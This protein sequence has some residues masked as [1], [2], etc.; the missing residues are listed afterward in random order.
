M[1]MISFSSSES[2][3][4]S[5]LLSMQ[6]AIT[7][8]YRSVSSA[9]LIATN[10]GSISSFSA[11]SLDGSSLDLGKVSLASVKD[12]WCGTS[13]H[14]LLVN[15]AVPNQNDR[16]TNLDGIVYIPDFLADKII[17]EKT[18]ESVSSY[19]DIVNQKIGLKIADSNGISKRYRIANVF[20]VNGFEYLRDSNTYDYDDLNHGEILESFIGPFLIV[21]DL[22]FFSI[23]NP[24]LAYVFPSSPFS[25]KKLGSLLLNNYEKGVLSIV[26]YSSI[27]SSLT[28]ISDVGDFAQLYYKG[29]S[30]FDGTD[31][32]AFSL[33]IL[34]FAFSLMLLCLLLRNRVKKRILGVFFFS[35]PLL[36]LCILEIVFLF[37]QTQFNSIFGNGFIIVCCVV[38]LIPFLIHWRS[39]RK[40]AFSEDKREKLDIIDL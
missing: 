29:I 22:S 35:P 13:F 15:I 37:N 18:Y 31:W 33:S 39:P 1:A 36:I 32:I 17:K 14:G 3:S 16:F 23:G 40:A 19:E 8:L 12:L 9:V 2:S 24:A 4:I 10:D 7:E 27:Q 5:D 25:P 30:I 28:P 20:H 38:G 34:F 6:L 21:N 11:T 26:F